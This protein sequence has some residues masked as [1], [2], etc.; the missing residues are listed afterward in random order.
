MTT[1]LTHSPAKVLQQLLVNLGAGTLPSAN[2]SWP[3]SSEQELDKPDGSIVVID[4]VGF[5]DGRNSVTAEHDYHHGFQLRLRHASKNSA[6]TKINSIAVVMDE[7]VLDNTVVVD[8]NTYRVHAITKR[9]DI[10]S[11]GR[12]P[13]SDRSIFTLNA[14]ITLRQTS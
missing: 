6:F 13:E 14:T 11:L 9:G 8:E 1:A 3:I 12:E 2:G 10:I 4:T 5:S 7:T